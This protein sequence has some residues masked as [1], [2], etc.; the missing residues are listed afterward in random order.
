MTHIICDLCGK[1]NKA[2]GNQEI[3]T[4]FIY[5]ARAGMCRNRIKR[6]ICLVCLGKLEDTMDG[7]IKENQ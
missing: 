3:W 2:N 4:E 7:L 6:D 1:N 5:Y